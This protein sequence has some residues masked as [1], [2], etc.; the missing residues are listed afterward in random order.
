MPRSLAALL[1]LCAAASAGEFTPN[2]LFACAPESDLVLEL[3]GDGA[4][5]W[6]VGGGSSLD[7]P[8][9]LAFGPDGLLYVSSYGSSRVLVFDAGGNILKALGNGGQMQGPRGL[10]FAAD[11]SLLVACAD[12][13]T[14]ERFT[15]TG[16]HLGTFASGLDTPTGLA[17]AGDGHVFAS[18]SGDGLVA[19][20]DERGGLVRVLG[21]SAGLVE[22]AAVVLV[23]DGR[24]AVASAG[25]DL[26]VLLDDAGAAAG[27]LAGDGTLAA[28]AGLVRGPDGN[29]WAASA[30]GGV[31]VMNGTGAVIRSLPVAAA[32]GALAFA[33]RRFGTT[34]KGTLTHGGATQA[35]KEAV[36]I[37]LD[38]GA[39]TAL[40]QFT[41]TT[42]DDDLASL[43][44]ASFLA[45]RGPL[46]ADAGDGMRRL[47]ASGRLPG[48]SAG[49]SASLQ[50]VLTGTRDVHGLWLPDSLAG[51]LW[52]GGPEAG[53]AARLK[54]VK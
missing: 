27:Q 24:L 43:L 52:R 33:P 19:E 6:Q 50:A 40:V 42:A 26:V 15:T 16:T 35:I 9:G 18:T 28:P 3:D 21:G 31:T 46:L 34:L 2:H 25:S 20:L 38:P 54:P 39:G 36:T 17:V 14:I 29:L 8:A 53:L 11:G 30:D 45:L 7:Q 12:E 5:V 4:V 23:P 1:V 41:N 47:A 37:A 22:P 32:R 13:G 49:S 44:G 48:E 10:A 51:D